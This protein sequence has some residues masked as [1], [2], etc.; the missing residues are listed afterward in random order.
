LTGIEALTR[1]K[2]QL[3]GLYFLPDAVILA[4]GIYFFERVE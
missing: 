1:V 3:A 2:P 4:A